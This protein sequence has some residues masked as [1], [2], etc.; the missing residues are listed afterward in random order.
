[1]V[2]RHGWAAVPA[3]IPVFKAV[4][5]FPDSCRSPRLRAEVLTAWRHHLA[6]SLL[7]HI[8]LLATS[9]SGTL[10]LRRDQGDMAM[11]LDSRRCR[12]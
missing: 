7:R 2:G 4:F 3:G 1:M 5:H 6:I 11:L 9:I 10:L 8:G 12:L